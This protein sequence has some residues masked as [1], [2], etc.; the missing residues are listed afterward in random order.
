MKGFGVEVWTMRDGKIAIWKRRSM[1]RP[2]IKTS[3][4]AKRCVEG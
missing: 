1:L 3:I 2:Q 4:S